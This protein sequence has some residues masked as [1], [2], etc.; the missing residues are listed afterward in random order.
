MD[1][2]RAG[3]TGSV[4]RNAVTTTVEPATVQA[5]VSLSA[6]GGERVEWWW[7]TRSKPHSAAVASMVL[8]SR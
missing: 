4:P 6:K 1:Q 7:R 3:R 5:R 8:R 2:A